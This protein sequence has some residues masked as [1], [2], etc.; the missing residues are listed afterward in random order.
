V[1][2]KVKDGLYWI[3]KD[4]MFLIKRPSPIG[5]WYFKYLEEMGGAFRYGWGWSEKNDEEHKDLPCIL[6]SSLLKWS[7]QE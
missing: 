4:K 7:Y 2:A 6:P 1:S 3:S 5:G